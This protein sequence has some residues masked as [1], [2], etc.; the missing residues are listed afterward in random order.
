MIES[1][2]IIFT[3]PLM[4][5]DSKNPPTDLL[6]QKDHLSSYQGGGGGGGVRH[7]NCSEWMEK[8]HLLAIKCR[9]FV[10]TALI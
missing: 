9:Y 2:S 10:C 4:S 1:L 8:S 5:F 7:R 6:S 3:V